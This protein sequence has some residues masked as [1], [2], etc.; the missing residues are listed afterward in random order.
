[1]VKG[2]GLGDFGAAAAEG[3]KAAAL[4]RRHLDHAAAQPARLVE[5]A[6]EQAVRPRA[7]RLLESVDRAQRGG[8]LP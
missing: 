5:E 2:S 4:P 1:M 6:G 3:S 7:A 8:E